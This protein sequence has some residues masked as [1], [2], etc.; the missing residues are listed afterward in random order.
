MYILLFVGYSIVIVIIIIIIIIYIYYTYI[1]IYMLYPKQTAVLVKVVHV[2]VF[3][4][5][6]LYLPSLCLLVGFVLILISSA[7]ETYASLKRLGVP[8]S[9]L[10]PMPRAS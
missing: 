6:S 1:Y 10:S 2:N 5:P 3:S 8:N 9:E 7:C 4:E